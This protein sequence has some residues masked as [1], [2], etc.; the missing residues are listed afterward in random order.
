MVG[1]SS[2]RSGGGKGFYSLVVAT[3]FSYNVIFCFQINVFRENNI[4]AIKFHL[5][6]TLHNFSTHRVENVVENSMQELMFCVGAGGGDNFAY[7]T[8]ISYCSN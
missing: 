8:L 2:N 7:Q 3:R 4:D 6:H 1:D 5:K